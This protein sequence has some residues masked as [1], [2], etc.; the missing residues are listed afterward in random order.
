MLFNKLKIYLSII[1]IS[2]TTQLYA[3]ICSNYGDFKKYNGHYYTITTNK[4]TF[5]TAKKLAEQNGGYLAIPNNEAENKFITSLVKGGQYAWIGIYDPDNTQN[6][7]YD[8]SSCAYDDSRF[9][10]VKNETL[11]YTNWATNQP[12]NLVHSYDVIN[13]E[14]KVAPLGEH[15]VAIA[16]PSGKWADFGNH[17]DKYNNPVKFYAIYEFETMPECYT[18]N[19]NVT[20]T[21]EG[22]K[23]NTKIYDSKIDTV[24]NGQ[25]F[26]CQQD[27]YGTDYCPAGLSECSQEWD[28]EDGYSIAHTGKT[29]EKY[30]KIRIWTGRIGDNYWSGTCAHYTTSTYF[31]ITNLD[32]VIEFKLK[33]AKFDDW[34]KV[35]VNGEIIRV[36][37]YGGDRLNLVW[38]H[39]DNTYNTEKE[40]ED[41]E[42]SRY[43]FEKV[44]YTETNT[45]ACELS[46]SWDQSLD[47]DAKP[48]LI[49]GTN[50]VRIDV[51]VS[52]GGEGYAYFEGI[53]KKDNVQCASNDYCK[54]DNIGEVNITAEYTYYE[55]LCNN[56]TNEYNETYT[57]QDTGGDCN[58]SSTDDLIDTDGDGVG[59]S[60]NEPNPP[61]NNCKRKKFTCQESPN[62]K[63][64]WVD[65]KW[66][67]SPFPC[68]GGD[69]IE[70]TDTPV[71]LNDANNNGWDNNGNC[72]GQIY[73]FNG[74]DNR[75][76]SKDIFFGLTG[77]GCCNKDKVF[78]GLI[79][80]KD[81]EK[82][83]AKL[84]KQDRCH[85]IGEY[86]SKKLKIIGCIQHKKSYCCFNSKL[87]RIINEQGRSQLGKGWGNAKSP[88]CKGFTPEEF[89]KL[90]FS[91]LDL[92]EFFGDIQQNF[93]VNFIGNQQNFIKNRIINNMNNM[94]LH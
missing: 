34:I 71:G 35:T 61:T 91:K 84:R 62:R 42:N 88:Q 78:L 45:G 60:C 68:I 24:K 32:D 41:A 81:D 73:I 31:N 44:Q 48:Y 29:V 79:S 1:L 86:C 3:L 92:S 18:P 83:L 63:C 85:Y 52:G 8:D 75:C 14:K 56:D 22:K 51:I 69:D 15:W 12:D 6:Y 40:C 89:Q 19:S 82:K 57:P 39:G 7:C 37:P 13:G 87:A 50:V 66:Q 17:F 55:Y 25:T 72:N 2:M 58:P 26:D 67:C 23:C 74:K 46:T 80:C 93:N 28:Y 70:T 59:D 77:G 54:I 5:Q 33:R 64:A 94:N 36:G 53:S 76:R 65:N 49:E 38:K 9:K 90:D 16:S 10:T 43:C 21:I 4:L 11:T 30:Q 47:I 27:K 20:D